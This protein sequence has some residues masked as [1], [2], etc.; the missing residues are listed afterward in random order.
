MR[1]R[2]GAKISFDSLINLV[3][4]SPCCIGLLSER[5][6]IRR[7]TSSSEVSCIYKDEQQGLVYCG[8]SEGP[9]IFSTNLDPI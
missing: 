4:I 2:N 1:V 7:E 3:F 8:L 6:S 9:A 5:F